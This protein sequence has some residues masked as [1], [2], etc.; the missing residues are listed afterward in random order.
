MNFRR[1]QMAQLT[2]KSLQAA[3]AGTAAALRCRTCLQPAGGAGDKVFP[4]TYAGAVYAIEQR[5]VD[6]E[7]DPV[8]CVLLDSVQSQANRQEDALQDAFD[9]G[10]IKLP[11]IAVEFPRDGLL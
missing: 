8:T 4:P 6:G 3:V 7:K 9:Q 10:R 5:R 2:L 1:K 11:V